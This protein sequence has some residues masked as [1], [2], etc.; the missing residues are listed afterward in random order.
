M[1][2]RKETERALRACLEYWELSKMMFS[3]KDDSLVDIWKMPKSCKFYR[4]AREIAEDLGIRWEGMTCEQSDAI[5][6]SLLESRFLAIRQE[7]FS[8]DVELK[9]ILNETK[10]NKSG[11]KEGAEG[12]GPA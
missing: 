8:V 12:K 7:G 2:H 4:E 6:L 10:A 3:D 5:S 9:I 11:D 1:D